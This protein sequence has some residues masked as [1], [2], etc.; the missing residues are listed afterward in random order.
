MYN[1]VCVIFNRDGVHAFGGFE[2][3]DYDSLVA[4]LKTGKLPDIGKSGR[5]TFKKKANNVLRFRR[6]DED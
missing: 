4:Y 2:Q 1:E 6:S 5:D 3:R